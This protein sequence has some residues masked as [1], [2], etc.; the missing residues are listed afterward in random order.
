MFDSL[1]KGVREKLFSVGIEKEEDL[2]QK[3]KKEVKQIKGLGPKSILEIEYLMS[4]HKLKFKKEVKSCEFSMELRKKVITF[5]IKTTSKIN[6]GIEMRNAERLLKQ[7]GKEFVFTIK[8]RVEVRTLNYFFNQY[9]KEDLDRKFRMWKT[10][11]LL[12]EVKD[13]EPVEILD[14][15][16]GEDKVISKPK[17][18]KDFL[19]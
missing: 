13:T 18:L 9:V 17:T 6:W 19:S 15:K 3:T 2:C 14:F 10:P 12:E 11:T 16:V 4:Q 7:Y 1:N 8:P 5:F